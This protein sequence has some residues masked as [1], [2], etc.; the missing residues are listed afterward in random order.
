MMSPGANLP[1]LFWHDLTTIREYQI[2]RIETGT[3]SGCFLAKSGFSS[4][5][6]A[7]RWAAEP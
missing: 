5:H 1:H 4:D 7:N 3:E 2:R 6:I